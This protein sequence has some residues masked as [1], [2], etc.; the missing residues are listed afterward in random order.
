[1]NNISPPTSAIIDGDILAF[2]LCASVEREVNLTEHDDT[3]HDQYI[4]YSSPDEAMVKI[5]SVLDDLAPQF[6]EVKIALS[7]DRC[8][9]YDIYPEYKGNRAGK[10]KPLA[11]SQV[12][13]KILENEEYPV[14]AL[15]R[16]EADDVMGVMS[17]DHVIL[18]TDK[19][20]LTVPGWH[21]DL[22]AYDGKP[23]YQSEHEA[24]LCWMEQTLIGD[25][26][27]GY[28]GCPGVGLKTAVKI[29]QKGV[30]AGTPWANKNQLLREI[31]LQVIAAYEKKD[32]PPERAIQMARLAR[33]L[34]PG[35]L[36]D[37]GNV[38]L[39]EPE[40]A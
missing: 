36:D 11:Y 14:V 6:D 38:I 4:W 20:L 33:I 40:D 34:R 32:L 2:T 27:D 30:D 16:F 15:P 12:L 29:I 19:D 17:E 24:N 10:K 13:G 28:P 5:M 39:W 25:A 18:T 22:W 21:G 1:M 31:W 3:E 23:F 35:D 37:D 8:F 9:R 7:L 26:A